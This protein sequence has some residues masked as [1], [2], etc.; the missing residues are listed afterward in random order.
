M[1]KKIKAVVNKYRHMLL[2]PLFLIQIAWFFYCES[3]VTNPKYIMFSPL[4]NYI[5]FIKEFVVMY[6]FWYFYMAIAFIYLGMVSPDD[7]YKLFIF[8]FAGMTIAHTVYLIFPNGQNLRPQITGND[9][10]SMA[11]KYLY[12]IDT[13]TNVAP[14]VH[15]INS[16]AVYIAMANCHKLKG[17]RAIKMLL[18]A[19]TIAISLSTMF[20]KQH[21]VVDVFWG[22]IVSAILYLLIYKLKYLAAFVKRYQQR[23]GGVYIE[24]KDRQAQ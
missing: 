13:P 22:V 19:C 4:D 20:I 7:F 12:K 21:S 3:V 23:N 16:F 6:V 11:V 18:L 8:I 10:F 9:I 2:L 5:P 24:D 17:K 15:V 14:S 1:A